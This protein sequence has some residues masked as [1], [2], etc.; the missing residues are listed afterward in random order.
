MNEI[1][2]YKN[3]DNQS[4]VEVK[5]EK[6]TFW[7]S[8]NQIA[9]LFERDKSVVSRHLRNIYNERELEESATVAKNATVQIEGSREVVR[10]VVY[11]NLD[12]IISVGYRVN[13][14]RGTQFRQWATN[15]LRE[16]LVEGYAINQRRLEE[17][18]LELRQLKDGIGIL[19]GAIANEA[20]SLADALAA[21]T[22]FIAVSGPEEM[23]TVK[24][25]VISVLNRKGE[26]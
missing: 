15:R 25:V 26:A 7:L 4:Q 21:L 11:Y 24:K 3:E 8:L 20:R 18:N 14:K 23:D 5:F 17:K 13:S 22:L 6:D 19:R 1:V 16:Y 12:A 2:I 10:D 9:V